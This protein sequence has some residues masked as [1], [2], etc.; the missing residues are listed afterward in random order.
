[1]QKV[2]EVSTRAETDIG[3][4]TGTTGDRTKYGQRQSPMNQSIDNIPNL[5]E[6]RENS[7]DHNRSSVANEM[8][9]R[10]YDRQPEMACPS[11]LANGY[12]LAEGGMI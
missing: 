4:H 8:D 5:T 6:I 2:Q 11:S 9:Q 12:Q 10:S 7:S 3:S 1:M